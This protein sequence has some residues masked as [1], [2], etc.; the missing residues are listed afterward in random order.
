MRDFDEIC[1]APLHGFSSAEDYY[2]QSSAR[3][4]LSKI[5]VPTVLLASKD[6]PFMHKNTYENLP[7]NANVSYQI[8]T[9]GGHLGFVAA[10]P[11]P[12]R[13]RR[14]LDYA[15]LTDAESFLKSTTPAKPDEQQHERH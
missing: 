12:L 1:T 9:N 5:E 7:V 6:D 8:E 4:F 10:R 15:V 3:Q 13:T 11:T 14:W 2:E